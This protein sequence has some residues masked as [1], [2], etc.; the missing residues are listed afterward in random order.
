LKRGANA[1]FQFLGVFVEAGADEICC[2]AREV[3]GADRLGA[4]DGEVGYLDAGIFVSAMIV[5]ALRG[6]ECC[7]EDKDKR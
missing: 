4:G 2:H 5:R 1:F 7:R 3:S 6:Q